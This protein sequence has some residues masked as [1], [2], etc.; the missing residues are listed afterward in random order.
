MTASAYLEFVDENRVW[1]LE[2]KAY[3]F[4]VTATESRLSP[5]V[6][7]RYLF[8]QRCKLGILY[9]VIKVISR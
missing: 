2:V 1:T 4:G 7:A 5:M 6:S 9:P 8:D 3:P